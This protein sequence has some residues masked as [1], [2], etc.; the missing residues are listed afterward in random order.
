MHPS[1]PQ[2]PDR[3]HPEMLLATNSESC[4]PTRASLRRYSERYSARSCCVANNSS[5][6]AITKEWLGTLWAVSVRS[7]SVRHLIIT[8]VSASS[9]ARLISGCERTSGAV[10]ARRPATEC[11]PRRGAAIGRGGNCQA[12]RNTCQPGETDR[13]PSERTAILKVRNFEIFRI[14]ESAKV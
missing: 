12:A 3:A 13:D 10:E 5:S 4:V 8:R 9:S 11:S 1:Q 14:R 7:S 6:F 2:I